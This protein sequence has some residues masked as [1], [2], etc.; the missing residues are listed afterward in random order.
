M[1]VLS[2]TR[3]SSSKGSLPGQGGGASGGV[4]G[5]KG[6]LPYAKESDGL[7][8]DGAWMDTTATESEARVSVSVCGVGEG[9]QKA[10][11]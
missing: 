6:S 3:H 1:R 9:A 2:V 10:S 11:A 8:G 4:V 7:A 5:M